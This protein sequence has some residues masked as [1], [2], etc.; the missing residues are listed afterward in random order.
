MLR[1][2]LA[3]LSIRTGTAAGALQGIERYM[4]RY[5]GAGTLAGVWT[6]E[7]GVLNQILLLRSFAIAEA[8]FDERARV[9]ESGE[10]FG[11]SE[12]LSG[13]TFETWAPYPFVT[14]QLAGTLG[15]FYE[16]RVYG[17]KPGGM[18][19]TLAAWK[20]AVPA[21][22]KLSPIVVAAYA[23]DGATPRMLHVCP[24]ANLADRTRIRGEA[25]A[26]G[27]WPPTSGPEWQTIMQSTICVPAKFSPLR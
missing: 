18:R 1:L 23:L 27:G 11:A 24:Y 21:R 2:E 12:Q 9:I 6:T 17:I 4:A 14:P 25:V 13:C 19:P 16:L 8:L 7:V 5:T 10:F 3:T 20:A 22:V 26:T 15:A